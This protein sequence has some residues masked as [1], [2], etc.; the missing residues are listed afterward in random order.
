MMMWWDEIQLTNQMIKLSDLLIFLEKINFSNRFSIRYFI[1]SSHHLNFII[2][3]LHL[4]IF[5]H[6]LSI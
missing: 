6:T 5:Q 1:N 2:A 4:F 3:S